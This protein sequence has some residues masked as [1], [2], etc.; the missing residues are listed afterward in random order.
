MDW[1]DY[2]EAIRFMHSPYKLENRTANNTLA[3]NAPNNVMGDNVVFINEDGSGNLTFA[4]NSKRSRVRVR[5][6][7]CVSNC[8]P[9]VPEED[10]IIDPNRIRYWSNP[11]DWDHYLNGRIPEDGDE[12]EIRLGWNMIFDILESPKLKKLEINGVLSLS[13]EADRSISAYNIWVR[14]GTF[15]IGS[16]TSPF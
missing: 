14:A 15:N 8:S 4:V 11:L 12:I 9:D 6:V 3:E 16:S 7:S 13:D 1:Y 5:E 10:E 2:N